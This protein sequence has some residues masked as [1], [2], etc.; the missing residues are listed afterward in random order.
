MPCCDPALVAQ[1]KAALTECGKS[2]ALVAKEMGLSGPRLSGVLNA[3][4]NVDDIAKTEAIIGTWLGKYAK[5]KIY[6]PLKM[7]FV[8]TSTA[9]RIFEL[10]ESCRLYKE[11]GVCIGQAGVGKTTSIR[12]Y[13]DLHSDVV[14]VY[15]NHS[16]TPHSLMVRLAD[17]LGLDTKGSAQTLFDRCATRLH[18]G[19][20]CVIIDEAEHLSAKMIDD[21]RRLADPEVGGCG[22]LFVGLDQFVATLT[23]RRADYAYLYSRVHNHY[24]A[25]E[26]SDAGVVQFCTAAGDRFVPFATAFAA[27]T[28]NPRILVH[29]FNE[30][31]RICFNTERKKGEPCPLGE[32]VIDAAVKQ[33]I[34]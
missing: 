31:D 16:M 32:D 19:D 20:Y 30:C 34:F 23:S 24:H 5:R 29:L 26:L 1:L 28:H 27:R 11:L 8:E 4:Y 33:L 21:L 12:Q 22:M 18:T 2:Q 17:G 6:K 3:T 25:K 14:L 13:A 15:S 9:L 7:D 10:A